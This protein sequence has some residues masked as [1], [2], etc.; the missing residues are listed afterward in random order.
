MQH[1][2]IDFGKVI[3]KT[4]ELIIVKPLMLPYKIYINALVALSNTNADD[5]E[6]SNLSNDFP[7]YIWFVSIFNAIIFLSYPLGIVG[8]LIAGF[9]SYDG[10]KVFIIMLIYTYFLPLVYG[11]AREILQITLKVL[12][13]LK[14]ISKK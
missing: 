14:I 9:N 7:L 8:S 11:F 1:K 6:E 12:L 3:L 10:F 13:Y 4:L 2:E 5:S